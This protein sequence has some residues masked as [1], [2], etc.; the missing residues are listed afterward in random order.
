MYQ[1]EPEEDALFGQLY[2]KMKSHEA[3]HS[4]REKAIHSTRL[5]GS[6]GH[7]HGDRHKM[8]GDA[9]S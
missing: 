6:D 3:V 7:Q 2:Y 9:A 5:G 8:P 4:A 1:L